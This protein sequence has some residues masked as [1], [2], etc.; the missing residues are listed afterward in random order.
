MGNVGL[1][2]ITFQGISSNCLV[3]IQHRQLGNYLLSI[4]ESY[5]LKIQQIFKTLYKSIFDT[6]QQVDCSLWS[7]TQY[8]TE[9]CC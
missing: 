4:G 3:V 8:D 7:M 2:G 9:S 6:Y 1:L 5:G